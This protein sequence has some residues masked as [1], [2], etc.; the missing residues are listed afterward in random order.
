MVVTIVL[1]VQTAQVFVPWNRVPVLIQNAF[2]VSSCRACEGVSL[3]HLQT[4]FPRNWEEACSWAW[5]L[6]F[7]ERISD[8]A[9]KVEQSDNQ[10]ALAVN[11]CDCVTLQH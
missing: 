7:H 9:P 10:F 6:P 3:D 4:R 8:A 2:V 5:L 1:V 11:D